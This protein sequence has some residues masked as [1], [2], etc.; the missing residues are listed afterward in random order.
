M[1]DYY[2]KVE[3]RDGCEYIRQQKTLQKSKQTGAKAEKWQL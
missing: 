1:T 3:G 2:I